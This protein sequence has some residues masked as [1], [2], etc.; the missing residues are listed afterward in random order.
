M[1]GHKGA[2]SFFKNKPV[3]KDDGTWRTL[4]QCYFTGKISQNKKIKTKI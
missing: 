2:L 1:L 3:G 4:A